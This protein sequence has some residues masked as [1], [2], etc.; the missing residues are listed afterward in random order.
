MDTDATD[1]ALCAW[2]TLPKRTD[3]VRPAAQINESLLDAG[4]GCF[5]QGWTHDRSWWNFGMVYGGIFLEA[6]MKLVPH[7]A[8]FLHALPRRHAI[9]LAGL[10]VLEPGA[11]IPAHCDEPPE[12]RS[13]FLV[14]HYGLFGNGGLRVQAATHTIEQGQFVSFRDADEHE[15]WN[16]SQSTPR[17]VLYVKYDLSVT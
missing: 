13:R 6:N 8:R 7:L 15:A 10:S 14:E 9:V 1:E 2:Q 11:S 17:G 12:R 5:V 4:V 3:L 16:A